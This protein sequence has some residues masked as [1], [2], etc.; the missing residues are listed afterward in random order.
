MFSSL[1][2]IRDDVEA[3]IKPLLPE[4]WKLI[5]FAETVTTAAAPTVY[6]AFTRIESEVD[7]PLPRGEAAARFD[8]V[9]TDPLTD[10]EKAE[11]AVDAHVT[12]LIGLLEHTDD[13]GWSSAEK[14]RLD[15]GQMAWVIDILALTLVPD[16]T[17]GD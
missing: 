9:I 13:V 7:G 15:N 10:T 1:A 16:P 4:S 8:L 6:L 5:P 2:E 14:R 12:R 11:D 3:W 17:E